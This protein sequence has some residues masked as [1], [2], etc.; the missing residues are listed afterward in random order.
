MKKMTLLAIAFG[1]CVHSSYS[2]TI[3]NRIKNKV[4]QSAAKKI[5]D[6]INKPGNK[7]P[8]KGNSSGAE[9][10]SPKTNESATTSA[11]QTNAKSESK[12][13]RLA[14]RTRYDFVPADKVIWWEDFEKEP[15]GEFPSKWFTRS[16]AETVTLN[17]VP[18]KWMRM[19]PGG[20]LSP[21]VDM[22]EDYTVE[23]DL[24]MDW[25]VKG[26]F[27]VPSFGVSFYDRG[28]K[29]YVFS[30]DYRMENHMS[31]HLTPFRSEAYLEMSTREKSAPKFSSEKVKIS[32][33]ENKS[34]KPVHIAISVQKERMRMW[35][36]E[37]KIFDMPGA[38]PYPGNLN[39]LKV[40]MNSS[41][42][43][44]EE[45]GYYVTNFKVAKG[46]NDIK[47]KLVADGKISTTGIRFDVNA[48]NLRPE[49]YGV[50][51]EIA[52]VMKENPDMKIRVVGHTDNSGSAADNLILSKKR[53]D[54]VVK[55]LTE[56]HQIPAAQLQ[57][58]GKGSTAPAGDNKTDEGRATNR[59]VEFI[60]L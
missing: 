1:C 42:Y 31:I 35:V 50:I 9:E 48:D 19:Y 36:D 3:F 54:A 37:E 25:P 20:F 44:N 13:D 47:S 4:S 2:Q 29:N 53:A 8:E 45:I 56:T 34:G 33:F 32:D 15:I 18:G 55:A 5:E 22:T 11:G 6:E 12:K 60:R 46:T 43:K 30:Y 27:L 51:N 16:K 26:G 28:N 59:R 40:E 49:S 14:A 52:K 17:D 21:V 7:E 24:I 58:D 23:F 38:A 41:N 57:S 39:Q 10:K